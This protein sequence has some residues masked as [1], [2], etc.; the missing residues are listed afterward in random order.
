MTDLPNEP[1][2]WPPSNLL[3]YLPAIYGECPFLGRFLLAFEKLL[4]GRDDGVQLDGKTPAA[5]DRIVAGM[6]AYWI[7]RETPAD[8]LPWLASWTAFSLRFDLD[9]TRQ[10]DFIA[11]IIP[12]YCERGTKRNLE[13][14]LQI[15]TKG[16]PTITEAASAAPL[17]IGKHSTVGVDTTIGGGVPHFFSITV[18]LPRQESAMQLRQI[19]IAR[20]LIESEKPAHTFFKPIWDFPSMQ[21]GKHS[22]VGIDTLLGTA[23]S[24]A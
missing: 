1:P 19:A 12:L 14:L 15:F 5:L 23:Q 4:F 18:R 3:R 24:G 20:A 9:E 8:F 22:T 21:I 6:P 7:P 2:S 16:A 11:N 13:R 10:R 17:Q